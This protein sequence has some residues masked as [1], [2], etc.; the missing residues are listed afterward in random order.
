MHK[1]GDVY[2]IQD[3]GGTPDVSGSLAEVSERLE[4]EDEARKSL[5]KILK[6]VS[7]YGL[8]HTVALIEM[9]KQAE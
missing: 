5:A 8:D 9:I 4:D 2:T 7:E 6:M 1:D 3:A